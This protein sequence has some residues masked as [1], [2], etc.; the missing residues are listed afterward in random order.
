MLC[1]KWCSIAVLDLTNDARDS[2]PGSFPLTNIRS[3]IVIVHGVSGDLLQE[4]FGT[5]PGE[6]RSGPVQ[7]L[8][9]FS[10]LFAGRWSTARSG[11]QPAV[12]LAS[13]C[14]VRLDGLA[15]DPQA[16]ASLPLT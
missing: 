2:A 9:Q 10:Q 13:N 15:D 3:R 12:H 8:E 11:C 6:K 14:R 7:R 16:G 5:L 1:L 4:V